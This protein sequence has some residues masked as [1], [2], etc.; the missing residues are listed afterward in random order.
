MKVK[1][2]PAKVAFM[3]KGILKAKSTILPYIFF[4]KMVVC[5]FGS[6]KFNLSELYGILG[7]L[8]SALI[9]TVVS[10]NSGF[11]LLCIKRSN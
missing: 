3:E 2:L 9:S 1:E 7:L 4:I 5:I 11:S 6:V 10:R 8:S